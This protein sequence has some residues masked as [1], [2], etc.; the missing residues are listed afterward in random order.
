LLV[1][2]SEKIL[3]PPYKGKVSFLWS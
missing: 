3:N 2:F 1:S